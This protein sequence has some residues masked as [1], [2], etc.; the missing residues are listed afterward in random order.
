[1]TTR[2]LH[3]NAFLM[4]TGHHEASWRLPESD[5]QAGTDIDHYIHLAQTAERGGFD[6]IFF[7]DGPSLRAE[8]GRRPAGNLEPLT[9]LSAL[10]IATKRIGLIAT[11]STSYNSPYN[12]ARRF[13]SIDHISKGRVGWNI[14]TTAGND[15]ARN[16]GLDER[17]AHQTR[18]ERAEEFLD[19]V[20]GLWQSWD[21]DAVI[22]DK[23]SG[24]WGEDSKVNAIDHDGRFFTVAGPLNIPRSPQVYPLLVQAGSSESGKELAAKFA[25]AVFT[26]HQRLDD[27]VAF[28]GDV[29]S[30]A[31]KH[32]R[33]PAHV[34]ILPGIVPII[35]ATE[36][37]AR[38]K[39]EELDRLIRPEFALAQLAQTL[40][41]TPDE[42]SLDSQLPDDLPDEDEIEGAKSRYTLIVDLARREELTVRQLIAR[43]GGGRGHRTVVGT[44]EQIADAIEEWFVADAADGFNIMPPALPSGLEEFV[45]TVIPILQDRGLFRRGYESETLRGHY[46]LPLPGPAVRAG[47]ARPNA[48]GE[49]A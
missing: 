24:V 31:I 30:R 2:T 15:A 27:A 37:E 48:V 17:P 6:S 21:D 36:A 38:A 14:V 4:T 7:A 3:L 39:D 43:L 46:G 20:Q 47:I 41:V 12:L 33:N 9:L 34:K 19:V 25:E 45:D 23:E 42:L 44:P 13:S 22:A 40:R 26:A 35:G 5:P 29:K 8:V 32:G 28:Y 11:A 1:M 16:F 49:V 10:A 18:Y